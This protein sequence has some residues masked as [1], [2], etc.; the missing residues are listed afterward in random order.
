[1]IHIGFDARF[2]GI[3]QGGVGR[4]VERVVKALG[5]SKEHFTMTLFLQRFNWGLFSYLDERFRRVLAD[6]PW[7]GWREQIALPSLFRRARCDFYHVPHFNVPLR[8][9]CPFVCTI[10]DLIMWEESGA[11]LSTH[12][13][14][15]ARVKERAMRAVV[16]R[17][18]RRAAHCIVP[19]RWTAGR[20]T[21]ITR[22]APERVTVI[23]EG[24]DALMRVLS[25]PWEEVCAR[26]HVAL[27]YVLCVGS[28]YPH[29]QTTLI[30]DAVASLTSIHPHL[31]LVHAGPLHPPSFARALEGYGKNALGKRYHEVGMVPDE[32]L[33]TLYR[34]ATAYVSAS[35]MEGFALPALE[36]MWH[37]TPVIAPASSC[38]P[39]LLGDAAMYTTPGDASS[40]AHAINALIKSPDT[41]GRY[42]E[43][44]TI[45]ARTY[46]WSRHAEALLQLYHLLHGQSQTDADLTQ[47]GADV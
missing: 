35:R 1:M 9:P 2:A 43:R 47:T 41:R 3:A 31:H 27:P 10:H 11:R 5:E 15:V 46:Q 32:I 40:I 25:R 42:A 38:F 16:R 24:A 39:E 13:K 45:L 14:V 7:Y 21:S 37:H 19:S 30:I 36:A 34:H 33:T 8:M 4:Y 17:A 28:A 23:P 22:I 29:K 26:Y 18:L 12:R 44:G 6:V 20:L